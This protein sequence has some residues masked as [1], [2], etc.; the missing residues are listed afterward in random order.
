MQ[1]QTA[2]KRILHYL[3]GTRTLGITYKYSPEPATFKGFA[4][5]ADK[6]QD[7]SKSTTGYVFIAAGS[8]ITW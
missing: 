5:A 6:N 3:S 4:D 8:A 2:L 7:N 1:H